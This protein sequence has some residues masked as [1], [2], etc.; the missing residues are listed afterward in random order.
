MLYV[1]DK[2]AVTADHLA[3]FLMR[4]P[5]CGALLASE[6]VAGIPGTLPLS[7][8]G[9]EGPRAPELAMSFRWDSRPNGARYPGHAPST[10][11]APGLG[12]HGSMSRHELRNILFAR[13]PS[14]RQALK[15]EAPSG[16]TDLAP[17][18]L[19]ILGL[20]F[21]SGAP[22][23]GRVLEEALAS[24]SVPEPQHVTETHEA[25]RPLE[26]GRVFRQAVTVSRVGTT[27]YVDQG[28]T[29]GS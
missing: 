21:Q 16:N 20:G 25:E 12:Q 6:A 22:M 17:T 27:T 2:D 3:N 19:R 4:Q 1:R 11:G 15:V 26:D 7:L 23:D 29:L 5:W 14:F 13:G 18:I 24:E 10:G 28:N 8:A 9:G